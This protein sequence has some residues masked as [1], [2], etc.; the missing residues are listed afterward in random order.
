MHKL[1]TRE[2]CTHVHGS[3]IT[4]LAFCSVAD[5]TRPA[6][7]WAWYLWLLGPQLVHSKEA[8]LGYDMTV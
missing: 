6:P 3:H 4:K 2:V 5:S 1:P 8:W 7:A